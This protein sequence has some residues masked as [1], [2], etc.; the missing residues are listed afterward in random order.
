M[1]VRSDICANCDK[2]FVGCAC[3]KRV[4][5]DGKIVHNTCLSQYNQLLKEKEKDN[6]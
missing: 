1:A 6:G 2:K 3:K 4:A 5:D